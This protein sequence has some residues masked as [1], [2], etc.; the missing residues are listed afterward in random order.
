MSLVVTN[1]FFQDRKE[2]DVISMKNR[3]KMQFVY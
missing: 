3:I 2:R 1:S